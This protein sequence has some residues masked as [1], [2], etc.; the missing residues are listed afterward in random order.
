LKKVIIPFLISLFFLTSCGISPQIDKKK[1]D[2]VYRITKEIDGATKV[3]IAYLNFGELLRKFSSEIEIT[4]DKISTKQE[5]DFLVLYENVLE[6]YQDSL[7]LWKNIIDYHI[8]EAGGQIV[9]VHGVI[10][11]LT[12][13]FTKY[14]IVLEHDDVYRVD[15]IP[16]TSLEQIWGEAAKK[17]NE[18]NDIFLGK[19]K[20]KQESPQSNETLAGIL[21]NRG[22]F[23]KQ[24]GEINQ[25]ISDYNEAIRQN[26]G[27]AEGYYNR[28]VAYQAKGSQSL[29]LSDLNQAIKI[30]PNFA[31]AYYGR[32]K[33]YF[34]LND[35]HNSIE[36]IRKAKELKCKDIEESFVNSVIYKEAGKYFDLVRPVQH[37]TNKAWDEHVE[38][39]RANIDPEYAKKLNQELEASNGITLDGVFFDPN[40]KS[41]AIINGK[42]VSEGS[43]VRGVI[44]DKINKDSV[45]ILVNGEK[46]NIKM[47]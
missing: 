34:N 32:A 29:A 43:K 20:P 17:S 19:R 1:F 22:N 4:K 44:V 8:D 31:E 23:Y 6:C 37:L 38:L 2:S 15:F 35:Y 3:G 16:K 5:K 47:Q 30:N 21:N 40:G 36:D 33:V 25:A 41:S 42:V 26:P 13:I 46:K 39:T 9:G 12:P 7:T 14:N 11:S 24:K 45:D 10:E 27:L 18:A 28:A